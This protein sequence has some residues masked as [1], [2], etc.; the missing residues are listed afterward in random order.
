MITCPQT[1]LVGVNSTMAGA[2]WKT[3]GLG[4]GVLKAATI[5]SGVLMC[6]YAMS[7]DAVAGSLEVGDLQQPAPSGMRCTV[8]ASR[9]GQFDCYP[10]AIERSHTYVA[11]HP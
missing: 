1:A 6:H 10:S 8:D 2:G 11:P 5:N 4:T 7:H 3:G 9:S